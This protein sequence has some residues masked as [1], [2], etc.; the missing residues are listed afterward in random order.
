MKSTMEK[1][2]ELVLRSGDVHF[3]G[4]RDIFGPPK[5]NKNLALKKIRIPGSFRVV[6]PL[7]ICLPSNF[8]IFGQ[9]ESS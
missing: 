1:R 9:K 3:H 8:I 5:V 7:P 6:K 2:M 4:F